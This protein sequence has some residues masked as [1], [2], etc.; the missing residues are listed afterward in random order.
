MAVFSTYTGLDGNQ[1][2]INP[3]P[4]VSTSL[5][6]PSN[7]NTYEEGSRESIAFEANFGNKPMFGGTD[8][9]GQLRTLTAEKAAVAATT[10]ASSRQ[11]RVAASSQ[12]RADVQVARQE[13][14]VGQDMSSLGSI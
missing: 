9:S 7:P 2:S 12:R 8:Y 13:R 10:K 14:L 5:F 4:G 1:T 6:G 11:N 3:F